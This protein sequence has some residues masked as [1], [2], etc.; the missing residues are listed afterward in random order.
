MLYFVLSTSTVAGFLIEDGC[1]D[2]PRGLGVAACLETAE[3]MV[4]IRHVEEATV[5]RPPS[6]RSESSH[7]NDVGRIMKDVIAQ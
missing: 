2:D 5:P 6:Q 1:G 4:L 3:L 7:L